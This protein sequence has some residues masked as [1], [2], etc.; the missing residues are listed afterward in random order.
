MPHLT[1]SL[2]VFSSYVEE[3]FSILPALEVDECAASSDAQGM[4]PWMAK[5]LVCMTSLAHSAFWQDEKR[6]NHSQPLISPATRTPEAAALQSANR[7]KQNARLE[8][9][10]TLARD[11]KRERLRRENVEALRPFPNATVSRTEQLYIYAYSGLVGRNGRC[12]TPSFLSAEFLHRIC[13]MSCGCA[14]V[15]AF[16][17]PVGRCPRDGL[18]QCGSPHTKGKWIF[19]SQPSETL[20]VSRQR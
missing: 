19:N 3:H 9:H 10:S 8:Q 18:G 7:R 15:A 11:S 2:V 5:Y 6:P 14:M 20:L 12:N 4:T 1:S 17:S 16:A 13:M